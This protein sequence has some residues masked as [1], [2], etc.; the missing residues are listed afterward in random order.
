MNDEGEKSGS[1]PALGFTTSVSPPS[2]TILAN[3]ALAF[4]AVELGGIALV[5]AGYLLPSVFVLPPSELSFRAHANSQ[6]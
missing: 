6:N 3:P 1:G 2:T 5:T 4:E